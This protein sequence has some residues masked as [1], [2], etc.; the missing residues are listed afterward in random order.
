VTIRH[1]GRI[2]LPV[3]R[4]P[5][6]QQLLFLASSG[7]SV[8]RL[9]V[10]YFF[11]PRL[12]ACQ[13]Q[14]AEFLP[15][16]KWPLVRMLPL[17]HQSIISDQMRPRRLRGA[18]FNRLLRHPARRRSGFILSPVTHTG[19]SCEKSRGGRIHGTRCFRCCWPKNIIII[20]RLHRIHVMLTI[21]SDVRRVCPSVCP[22]SR[23]SVCRECTERLRTAKR[24]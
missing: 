22:S 20:V 2:E 19:V 1:C 5:V 6:G 10:S 9:R 16:Y 24:A 23:H 14:R 21:V 11:E 8:R 18:W 4:R 12:L 17:S 7:T 15:K 3:L 13:L